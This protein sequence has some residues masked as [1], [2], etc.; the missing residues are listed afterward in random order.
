[1]L[2]INCEINLIP[3]WPADC[4]SSASDGVTKCATIDPKVYVPVVTLSTK[5]NS[6]HYKNWNQVLKKQLTRKNINQK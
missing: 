5:D 1:M 4:V 6:K 3:R 2:L